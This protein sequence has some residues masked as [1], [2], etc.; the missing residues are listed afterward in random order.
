MGEDGELTQNSILNGSSGAMS[1]YFGLVMM[2]R[3]FQKD[4]GKTPMR[5]ET[6]LDE[7][8]SG[9][10]DQPLVTCTLGRDS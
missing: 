3:F 4:G 1:H 5:K 8:E 7:M 9:D 10:W 6:A 2:T